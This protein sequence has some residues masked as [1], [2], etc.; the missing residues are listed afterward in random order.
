MMKMR[1]T[2]LRLFPFFF[3]SFL[4]AVMHGMQLAGG[5]GVGVMRETMS[6]RKLHEAAMSD[7]RY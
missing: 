5:G 3:P 7:A 6:I 2:L 1:S 4:K